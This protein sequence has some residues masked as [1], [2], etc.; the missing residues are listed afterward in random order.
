MILRARIVLTMEGPPIADGAVVIEGARIVE[1]GAFADIGKRNRGQVRDLGESVL[2]P[3][4]INA[5]C[6]LDY[7]ALRGVIPR[8]NSFTEWIRAIN[9]QKAAM[10]ENDFIA[11]IE[12]GFAEAARFGTTTIVNLEAFPELIPRVRRAALRTWWC[13]ELID[14]RRKISAREVYRRMK[15]TL[16]DGLANIGLAPHAPFTASAELYAEASEVARTENLLLTTHLAE[17]RDERQ[18]FRD[19]TGPLFEFLKDFGRPPD[20]CGNDSPLALLLGA[21]QL[22]ERWLIAHLNELSEDD[23]G[24]VKSAAKFHIVHCPRSH[25]FFQHAPFPFRRLARLG[26]N[27]CLGTDSLA[28]NS[29]LSLFRE[30]RAAADMHHLSAMEALAAVTVNSAKALGKAGELGRIG[31][32]FYADMI[33]IPFA[34]ALESAI[35]AVVEFDAAVRWGMV[36]G[37]IVEGS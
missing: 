30:M 23:F 6:H 20:D 16:P 34:G 27:I 22:D 18:M 3:G 35:E 32:G 9:E 25:Q 4:L 15:E 36:A 12:S 10:S 14:L 8:Q 13:A 11:S 37:V 5:H 17:S 33:A 1:V 21:H 19:A 28:S 24:L 26:F 7:T 2:L 31:P 29:D